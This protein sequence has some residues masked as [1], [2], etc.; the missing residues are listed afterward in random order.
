MNQRI[1]IVLFVLILLVAGSV[2]ASAG[3][4]DPF[5]NNLVEVWHPHT[6]EAGQSFPELMCGTTTCGALTTSGMDKFFRFSLGTN[7]QA[8]VY[9]DSEMREEP[10]FAPIDGGQWTPTVGHPVVFESR[11]R[12]SAGHNQDGSGD[13]V[14]TLGVGLWNNAAGTSGPNPEYDNITFVWITDEFTDAFGVDGFGAN[15]AWNLFPVVVSR[16]QFSINLQD[17]VDVKFI[18]SVDSGGTQSVQF[19]V[20]GVSTGTYVLPVPLHGLNAIAWQ[21]NQHFDDTFTPRWL[22]PTAVQTFDV[23]YIKVTQLQ[24]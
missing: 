7:V 9:S 15:V 6:Y 19:F 24:D 13:A 5:N 8:G 2:L 18:W 10:A 3:F 17:W 22:A 1:K 14:G 4:H 20:N 23:D 12:M 21:D 11:L 16:P